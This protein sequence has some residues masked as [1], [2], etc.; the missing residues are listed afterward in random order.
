MPASCSQTTPGTPAQ[1]YYSHEKPVPVVTDLEGLPH[2]LGSTM[3]VA[4]APK[5][6]VATTTTKTA[7]S[8][9]LAPVET[10]RPPTTT[11]ESQWEPVELAVSGRGFWWIADHGGPDQVVKAD[12]ATG[13]VIRIVWTE[14]MDGGHASGATLACREI[15]GTVQPVEL[16]WSLDGPMRETYNERIELNG[17]VIGQR[18][19]NV[20]GTSLPH[21]VNEVCGQPR[22]PVVWVTVLQLSALLSE[23][24][25]TDIAGDHAVDP[26]WEA[27]A[28]WDGREY[29]PLSTYSRDTSSHRHVP[30]QSFWNAE[31]VAWRSPQTFRLMPDHGSSTSPAVQLRDSTTA[32]PVQRS[33]RTSFE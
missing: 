12:L 10:V 26:V 22:F 13:E 3:T 7:T 15:D 16:F 19:M 17:D 18:T 11:S 24:G 4:A 21:E 6:I 23:A 30:R 8:R 20:D 28:S 14:P 1:A 32:R 29:R 9:D 33:T 2:H 25:F 27:N 31:W 5:A